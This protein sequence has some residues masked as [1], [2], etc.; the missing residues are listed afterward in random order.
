[1]PKKPRV[2]APICPTHKLRMM[3]KY[4]KYGTF[5]GCP[6]WPRCDAIVGAH[7]DTGE[8]LG[9]P[10]DAETRLARIKGHD[11]FAAFQSASNLPRHKV[12]GI[13]HRGLGIPISEC[14]FGMMDKTACEAAEHWLNAATAWVSEQ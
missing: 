9:T 1:M 4:G 8:P 11:A 7:Q 2:K 12:Y 14:H 3:R 10:G 5:W 13:L 6:E